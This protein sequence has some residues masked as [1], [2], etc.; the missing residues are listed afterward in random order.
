MNFNFF[1]LIQKSLYVLI[2]LLF[3]SC[4]SKKKIVY[5]QNIDGIT[6]SNS[7]SYE[8]KIQPDDLLMIIVSAEDP[9]IAIP[10]N[11]NSAAVP[12]PSNLQASVG[13][14]VMQFYLVDSNGNIEFPVLGKLHVGGMTRTEVLQSLKDKIGFYI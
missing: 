1:K 7:I 14:Q 5:Y 3:F 6:T 8:V 2:V 11:L 4:A 10:F 13:Q 12:N 9:E